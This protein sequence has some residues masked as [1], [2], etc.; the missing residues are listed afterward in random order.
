M[1]LG[2]ALYSQPDENID[3]TQGS[4]TSAEEGVVDADFEEVED[5]EKKEKPKS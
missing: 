2:E 4:G 1:K 5:E 3:A